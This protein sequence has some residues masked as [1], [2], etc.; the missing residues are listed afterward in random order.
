[1]WCDYT[2]YRTATKSEISKAYRKLA[3]KWHPDSYNGEEEE[4]A[5]KMFLD[6]AAAKEVLTDPGM[7][8]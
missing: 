8:V 7:Y 5:E 3:R 2:H 1:M 6:I 4:K